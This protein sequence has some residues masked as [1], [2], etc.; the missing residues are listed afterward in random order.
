MIHRENIQEWL[1]MYADNEL[2]AE[3]KKAVESYLQANPD[4]Q[5]ELQALLELRFIPEI[6]QNKKLLQALYVPLTYLSDKDIAELLDYADGETGAETKS[7]IEQKITT[8]SVWNDYYSSIIKTKSQ[9]ALNIVFPDKNSLYQ[10]PR[11]FKLDLA[12]M[13]RAVAIIILMLAAGVWI[14]MQFKK[15]KTIVRDNKQQIVL[16]KENNQVG[17]KEIITLKESNNQII[18]NKEVTETANKK[19]K[20]ESDVPAAGNHFETNMLTANIPV[21][22]KEEVQIKDEEVPLQEEVW[23]RP[24]ETI[25][26]T[27]NITQL[28][29]IQTLV[30]TNTVDDKHEP[31]YFIST[32]EPIEY[33]NGAERII[34]QAKR[35]FIRR[36]KHTIGEEPI[37][38]SIFQ[39]NHK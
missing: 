38:I 14:A 17:N 22:K 39:I 20:Y 9:P 29:T 15:E 30:H 33:Q 35:T 37:R 24:E 27:N 36:L 16:P 32:S 5:H 34:K 26:I 1:L 7:L 11:I 31:V 28:H 3:E 21:K 13:L 8:E 19:G 12:A 25:E 6:I 2:S 23:S 4:L 10:K 18:A